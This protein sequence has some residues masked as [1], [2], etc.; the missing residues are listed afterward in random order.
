M[1]QIMTAL[2]LSASLSVQA[3]PIMNFFELGIA[4]GQNAVYQQVAQHNIQTSL[5]NEKGT[6]AMIALQSQDNPQIGY[7]LELYADETAYQA[8]RQ[9]PHFQAYLKDTAAMLESKD[10]RTVQPLYLGNQGGVS[11]TAR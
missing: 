3:A 5:K 9:T 7:M 4:E 1:K 10:Y 6:L 11:W 8:H 2:A